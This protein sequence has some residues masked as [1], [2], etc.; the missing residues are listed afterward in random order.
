MAEQIA[1]REAAMTK[2][3]LA[4]RPVTEVM[5]KDY[6]HMLLGDAIQG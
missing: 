6:E 3:L 4:G 1:A 5:G 2:D